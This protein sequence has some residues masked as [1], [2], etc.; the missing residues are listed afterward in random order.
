MVFGSDEVTRVFNRFRSI[1]IAEDQADK[2]SLM[3]D[4]MN[5]IIAMRK[6]LGYTTTSLSPIELLRIFVN[7]I[8]Q[9]IVTQ[10]NLSNVTLDQKT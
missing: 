2:I 6:D 5:I 4:L 9:A 3:N 10:N 1:T 7:D 8:D